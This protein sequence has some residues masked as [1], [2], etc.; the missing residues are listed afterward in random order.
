[1]RELAARRISHARAAL[2]MRE[3]DARAKGGW[4][5]RRFG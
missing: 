3:L 4:L 5:A 2:V 1:M